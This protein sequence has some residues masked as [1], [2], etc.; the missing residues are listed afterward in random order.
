MKDGRMC[1]NKI[2]SEL[3]GVSAAKVGNGDEL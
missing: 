3:G 1:L 2:S